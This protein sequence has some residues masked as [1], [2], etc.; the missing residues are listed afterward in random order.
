MLTAPVF[1]HGSVSTM[2]IES[3]PSD[4][5]PGGDEDEGY[6]EASASPA[7]TLGL[8][9]PPFARIGAP[10]RPAPPPPMPPVR[11]VDTSLAMSDWG[12]VSE[13][14]AEVEDEGGTPRMAG[15]SFEHVPVRRGR[16]GDRPEG[17]GVLILDGLGSS[18][19]RPGGSLRSGSDGWSVGDDETL[20]VPGSDSLP[21]DPGTIHG[22]E[23]TNAAA[24][25]LDDDHRFSSGLDAGGDAT[26]RDG[27]GDGEDWELDNE[28]RRI[29]HRRRHSR[30]PGAAASGHP[31]R[32]LV[33]LALGRK[34]AGRHRPHNGRRRS[35]RRRRVLNLVV[36]AST[37]L[38][39]VLLPAAGLLVLHHRQ[40]E[41]TW[42]EALLKVESENRRLLSLEEGLRLEMELLQEEAAVAAA[43]AARAQELQEEQRRL[44]LEEQEQREREGPQR[45]GGPWLHEGCG[46]G[47]NDDIGGMST[48][49]DN[50]WVKAKA[51]IQLGDCADE[52]KDFFKELWDG[53]WK[54]PTIGV[55]DYWEQV[56]VMFE[57]DGAAA[58][59]GEGAGGSTPPHR[60]EDPDDGSERDCYEEG[61][62][63]LYDPFA[64]LMDALQS[65]GQSVASKFS[66]MMR[67]EASL[68]AEIE[69]TIH[70]GFSQ[71]S[72]AVSEAMAAA[73]ADIQELSSE[74]LAAL[75]GSMKMKYGTATEPDTA[76]KTEQQDGASSSSSTPPPQR[77]TRKGLFDAASAIAS[78]NRAWHDATEA[79]S[80]AA[81]DR[82][83]NSKEDETLMDDDPVMGV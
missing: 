1:D 42:Q 80:S 20:T 61:F 12:M 7:G 60:E 28:F 14:G 22:E 38:A 35:S 72:E 27:D 63:P 69:Q 50:C 49:V 19:D 79:V 8:L 58:G 2:E 29:D 62:Y 71:A 77:V 65:V 5:G 11:I 43:R 10:A 64:E 33:D 55:M 26:S 13:D 24:A 81:A 66:K 47:D 4:A 18:H 3:L 83:S 78:L 30:S 52:T 54:A 17:R 23:G 82:E 40:R 15:S 6:D 21:S 39:A 74:A 32:R 59:G 68:A 36:L 37:A 9:F 76:D 48:L 67:D 70:Q 53:L 46:D 57:E 25:V 73:R 51:D 75:K 41:R 16:G 34:A 31:L 56:S 44:F 45:R